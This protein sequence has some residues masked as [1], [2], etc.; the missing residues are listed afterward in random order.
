MLSRVLVHPCG[1]RYWSLAAELWP[2]SEGC[3]QMTGV[4]D[5]SPTGF[6]ASQYFSNQHGCTRGNSLNIK[7]W[8]GSL[9]SQEPPW[10]SHCG[11]WP[12]ALQHAVCACTVGTVPSPTFWAWSWGQCFNS[13]WG[14]GPLPSSQSLP[15]Q[16]SS[17]LAGCSLPVPRC[18]LEAAQAPAVSRHQ[19]TSMQERVGCFL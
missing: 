8:S 17:G 11:S 4:G 10:R 15:T 2:R 18:L 16:V 6:K 1:A 9:P 12:I 13:S 19:W 5:E 3:L 14:L 7:C